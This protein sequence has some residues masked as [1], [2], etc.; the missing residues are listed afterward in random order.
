[1]G[2]GLASP[3]TPPRAPCCCCG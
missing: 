2:R 1:M 3:W